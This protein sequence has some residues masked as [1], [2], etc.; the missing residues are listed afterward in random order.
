MAVVIGDADTVNN[1]QTS[2]IRLSYSKASDRIRTTFHSNQGIYPQSPLKGSVTYLKE[3]DTYDEAKDLRVFSPKSS[4]IF[5]VPSAEGFTP[6]KQ[7]AVSGETV[8]LIPNQGYSVGTITHSYS[9][10][11]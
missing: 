1:G 6:D 3:F 10:G 7:E 2:T 11:I 4:D 8:T 5:T 9:A